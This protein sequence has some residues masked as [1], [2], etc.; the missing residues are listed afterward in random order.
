MT[1]IYGGAEGGGLTSR[2]LGGLD[3]QLYAKIKYFRM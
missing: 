2:K 1:I 3:K